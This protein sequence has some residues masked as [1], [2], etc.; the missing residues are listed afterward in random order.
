MAS[1]VP[2]APPLLEEGSCGAL[3]CVEWCG[4]SLP[5]RIFAA[6]PPFPPISSASISVATF[7]SE[8]GQEGDDDWVGSEVLVEFR[9]K[10]FLRVFVKLMMK[11]TTKGNGRKVAERINAFPPHIRLPTQEPFPGNQPV[12]DAQGKPL[13]YGGKYYAVPATIGVEGGISLDSYP[14]QGT[15][16]QSTCPNAVVLNTSVAGIPPFA[17]GL[18]IV[19]YP[20]GLNE[21]Q[22]SLPL[23]VAFYREE[24]DPCA[25]ETVWKLDEEAEQPVIVT[26]GEIGD[27][28]D[29]T[30]WFRI[31]K[32]SNGGG[33][34][35]VFTFWPSLCSY[36]RINYWRIGTVGQGRQL[37]IN[38]KFPYPFNFVRA[39]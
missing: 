38:E 28:D 4:Y 10:G 3:L 25:K 23:N 6:H 19:F 18:P 33:W 31:E 20:R 35:Y 26:G 11:M 36:C 15:T 7:N 14:I 39:E 37:G 34:G 13:I 9:V 1:S 12:L 16:Q 8:G 21:V 30:N 29:V 24:S 2:L 22:E 27:E 32:N 17:K 5:P